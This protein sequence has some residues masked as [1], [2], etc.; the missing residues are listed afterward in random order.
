MWLIT[1]KPL[2]HRRCSTGSAQ[3]CHSGAELTTA[4]AFSVSQDLFVDQL[5]E[6]SHQLEENIALFEAQYL[7]QAEDTRVLRKAVTEV[8]ATFE[9]SGSRSPPPPT[10]ACTWPGRFNWTAPAC[11]SVSHCHQPCLRPA[12][13]SG[14]HRDRHHLHGEEADP[15]TV[16]HQ[17]S[18]HEAPER[19]IQDSDG[20]VQVPPLGG[21]ARDTMGQVCQ[22]QR[23][24]SRNTSHRSIRTHSHPILCPQHW[25]K[26]SP[27]SG[28]QEG[29]QKVTCVSRRQSCP[30][31]SPPKQETPALSRLFQIVLPWGC[32]PTKGGDNQKLPRDGNLIPKVACSKLTGWSSLPWHP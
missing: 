24:T 11:L 17:P 31:L 27:G 30:L 2:L 10:F 5:T 22:G 26:P 3:P 4:S 23:I 28:F 12:L 32:V 9:A 29:C 16:D 15:T 18:G 19:G 20:C 1:W 8:R 6:R 13:S 25:E 21:A 14:H 7:S